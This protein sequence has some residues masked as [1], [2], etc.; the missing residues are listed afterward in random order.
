MLRPD[1]GESE[2]RKGRWDKKL[3]TGGLTRMPLPQEML[4][5][6]PTPSF[7]LAQAWWIAGFRYTGKD[8]IYHFFVG[9]GGHVRMVIFWKYRLKLFTAAWAVDICIPSVIAW[10]MWWS[11]EAHSKSLRGIKTSAVSV[12]W[13]MLI[14]NRYHSNISI[15][16]CFPLYS[17][18]FSELSSNQRPFISSAHAHLCFTCDDVCLVH[19]A[20]S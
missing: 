18:Y 1:L 19:H 5:P 10:P 14:K 16:I 2:G 7:F 4:T 11:L 9:G 13:N 15:Q 3:K 6:A 17:T 8:D 20:S 12:Q